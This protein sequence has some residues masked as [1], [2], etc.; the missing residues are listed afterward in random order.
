MESINSPPPA[1]T[2]T[3]GDFPKGKKT[4]EHL[5]L[6]CHANCHSNRTTSSK[7]CEHHKQHFYYIEIAERVDVPGDYKSQSKLLQKLKAEQKVTTNREL[8]KEAK[9]TVDTSYS[10]EP[11]GTC[12]KKMM[13]K[14]NYQECRRAIKH[15]NNSLC[16]MHLYSSIVKK[17][18]NRRDT[19]IIL[20]SFATD[21]D[22]NFPVPQKTKKGIVDTESQ[23]VK[24]TKCRWLP[25]EGGPPCGIMCEKYIHTYWCEKHIHTPPAIQCLIKRDIFLSSDVLPKHLKEITVSWI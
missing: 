25:K 16:P 24:P 3:E 21:I 15:K 6:C 13:L 1:R 8:M 12:S 9:K 5:N 19:Q 17:L 18:K 11:L 20:Q 10:D 2:F 22:L 23:F 4:K 7:Y 14:G